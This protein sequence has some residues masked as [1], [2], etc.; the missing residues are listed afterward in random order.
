MILPALTF[1]APVNAVHYL[2]AR[3]IFMDCDDFYNIDV[4]KAIEFIERET[5]HSQ[6]HAV[7]RRT[8]RRISA[9]IPVHV[10]GNAVALEALTSLCQETNIRIV[11]DATESLGTW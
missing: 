2:G 1:I 6:G 4:V 5:R 3:P 9:L 8:G 11:E 10:F 7:N